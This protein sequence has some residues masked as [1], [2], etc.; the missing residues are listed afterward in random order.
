LAAQIRNALGDRPQTESVTQLAKDRA[1]WVLAAGRH[2]PPPPTW[3]QKRCRGQKRCPEPIRFLLGPL[4]G[5]KR[6][7]LA[8]Q[9]TVPDTFGASLQIARR[10]AC[11]DRATT[12]DKGHGRIEKRTLELTTW[13]EEYLNNDWPACRQ[14]FRLQREQ[15]TDEKVEVE[16]DFG[17]TSLSRE[18]AGATEV[19]GSVR[20]HWGIENGLH[21]RRD[22]T[23]KEDAGRVCK[24]S[25]PQV[26]A[27]LRNLIIYL[28]SFSGKASLA[29]ATHHYMCHPEKSV[30]LVS[31]PI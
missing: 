24:G 8:D 14:V 21:G 19:P 23:L 31:T 7:I 10:A 29:A 27:M 6:H 12:V 11:L 13:L 26:M 1:R 28:C 22:G 3:G 16:V 20:S 5:T 30:E 15:R 25:G 18:R 2:L 4:A 17:I 9:E